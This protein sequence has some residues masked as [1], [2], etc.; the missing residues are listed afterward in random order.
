MVDHTIHTQN[1]EACDLRCAGRGRIIIASAALCRDRLTALVQHSNGVGAACQ[2]IV[3]TKRER[4][5]IGKVHRDTGGRRAASAGKFDVRDQLGAGQLGIVHI[6]DSDG[7][8]GIVNDAIV[9]FTGR[10][11]TEAGDLRLR[12]GHDLNTVGILYRLIAG[13]HG[14]GLPVR[15]VHHLLSVQRR[16]GGRIV[17]EAGT[18]IHLRGIH[19]GVHRKQNL[20]CPIGCLGDFLLQYVRCVQHAVLQ[21]DAVDI[22][23]GAGSPHIAVGNGDIIGLGG[24]S[25]L[26]HHGKGLLDALYESHGKARRKQRRTFCHRHGWGQVRQGHTIGHCNSDGVL[27]A[28]TILGNNALLAFDLEAGDGSILRQLPGKGKAPVIQRI[29]MSSTSRLQEVQIPLAGI[30]PLIGRHGVIYDAGGVVEVTAGI[31]KAVHPVLDH[32]L[33]LSVGEAGIGV[34]VDAHSG[35]RTNDLSC[36]FTVDSTPCLEGVVRTHSGDDNAYAFLQLCAHPFTINLVIGIRRDGLHEHSDHIRVKSIRQIDVIKD[37][38]HKGIPCP[39]R[40]V[41]DRVITHVQRDQAENW[42]VYG[43]CSRVVIHGFRKV[44]HLVALAVSKRLTVVVLR[45]VRAVKS[46]CCQHHDGAGNVGHCHTC[47]GVQIADLPSKVITTIVVCQLS[48]I[49]AEVHPLPVI[50]RRTGV[51][52]DDLIDNV[53]QIVLI[54]V[55]GYRTGKG[56]IDIVGARIPVFRRNNVGDGLREILLYTGRGRN[57][58]KRRYLNHRCE[59][60][61]CSRGQFHGD[62]A[63]IVVENALHRAIAEGQN[64]VALCGRSACNLDSPRPLDA[65]LGRD[66]ILVVTLAQSVGYTFPCRKLRDPDL[67]LHRG[68]IRCVGDGDLHNAGICIDRAD[69]ITNAVRLDGVLRRR[70]CRYGDGIGS[71]KLIGAVIDSKR[72]CFAAAEVKRA[73]VHIGMRARMRNSRTDRGKVCPHRQIEGDRSVFLV[74]LA[75][76]G[77]TVR[78]RHRKGTCD[79]IGLAL[80]NHNSP[81]RRQ[82]RA[83]VKAVFINSRNAVIDNAGCFFPRSN[84]IYNSATLQR[85]CYL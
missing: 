30:A 47:G 17:R 51:S 75:V 67:R 39:D 7:V 80:F 70:L 77:H 74:D 8:L 10:L 16:V 33:P 23:L 19:T 85:A 3:A 20:R 84:V 24:L 78:C 29:R 69:R 36:R 55:F 46:S 22:Q 31:Y 64:I 68:K 18:E 60:G 83:H 13:G 44:V 5:C 11:H 9:P 49:E 57:R 2:I 6:G 71:F 52:G 62:L 43:V 14:E 48:L 4:G 27:A 82:I 63:R 21:L 28:F 54:L 42:A 35:K 79:R 76:S 26:S 66:H 25:V 72:L 61:R 50:I 15:E 41:G 53:L 59:G 12:L 40:V 58:G 1:G 34:A 45:K 73:A 81:V 65:V 37:H 32:A 56:N 38:I